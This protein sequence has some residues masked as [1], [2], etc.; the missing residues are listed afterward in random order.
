MGEIAP[1]QWQIEQKGQ[2]GDGI[3][4]PRPGQRTKAFRLKVQLPKATPMIVT[5]AAPDRRSALLYA[6]NRWPGAA[7]EVVK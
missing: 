5:M 3:S 4:R 7:V 6:K 2:F 1:F